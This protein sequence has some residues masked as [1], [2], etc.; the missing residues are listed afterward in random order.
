VSVAPKNKQLDELLT[1]GLSKSQRQIT[2]SW[3]RVILLHAK[4]RNT[5]G[6][7]SAAEALARELERDFV[8]DRRRANDPDSEPIVELCLPT[9]E[10]NKLI[11][12][13]IETI[14]QL[15]QRQRAL[16]EL[17]Q[18]G[19]DRAIAICVAL[20]KY[21]RHIAV[22]RREQRRRKSRPR[23]NGKRKATLTLFDG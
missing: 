13:G 18:V 16:A 9:N 20:Q 4:V 5:S 7:R 22:I 14:G 2:A 17:P 19:Q 6:I 21:D 1:V 10:H 11:D 8:A 3:V 23:Y 12:A 15:R